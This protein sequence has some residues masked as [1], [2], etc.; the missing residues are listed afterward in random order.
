MQFQ[1][2]RVNDNDEIA[3][4]DPEG[5]WVK[6]SDV[7]H[8]ETTIEDGSPVDDSSTPIQRVAIFKILEFTN[9]HLQTLTMK[10]LGKTYDKIEDITYNDALAIIRYA[11]RL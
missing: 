3:F 11:N 2:W 9:E 4:A 5:D 10:V 7:K 1:R 6:Y 8:L